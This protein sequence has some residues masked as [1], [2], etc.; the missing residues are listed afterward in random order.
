VRATSTSSTLRPKTS[1]SSSRRWISCA[2]A[3]ATRAWIGSVFGT[4]RARCCPYTV[5]AHVPAIRGDL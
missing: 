1:A 2:K 5:L 3:I 4:P